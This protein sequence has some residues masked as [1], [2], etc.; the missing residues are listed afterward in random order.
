MQSPSV[1]F[2]LIMTSRWLQR[3]AACGTLVLYV[4]TAIVLEIAH[5]HAASIQPISASR[6]TSHTCGAPEIHVPLSKVQN[7]PVCSPLAQR[8]STPASSFVPAKD[9]SSI[10]PQLSSA[11][12]LPVHLSY[13]HPGKRAPPAA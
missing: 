4:N 9:R 5:H 1:L 2:R 7:C 13:F 12:V 3:I 10:F 11:I 8:C 6:L